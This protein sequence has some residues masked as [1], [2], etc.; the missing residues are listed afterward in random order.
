ML[1]RMI[2]HPAGR[3]R[4]GGTPLMEPRVPTAMKA[5]VRKEP[6]GVV[7]FVKL[8][9]CDETGR[10]LSENFYWRTLKVVRATT[11]SSQPARRGRPVAAEEDFTDLE[12]MTPATVDVAVISHPEGTKHVFVVTLTN[13][14][15]RIALMVHLQLRKRKW[16]AAC[17]RCITKTTMCRCCR[18]KHA[19]CILRRQ[20][21]ALWRSTDG[22]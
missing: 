10:V 2:S 6:W 14:G 7:H 19:P 11:A 15:S 3:A 8:E 1:P 22:M 17:C 20:K 4:S 21:E 12:S 5:G 9:L 16:R 13:H 18:A